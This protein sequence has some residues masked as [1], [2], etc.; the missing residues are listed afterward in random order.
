[1]VGQFIPSSGN[2]SFILSWGIRESREISLQKGYI[3][4]QK[5]ADHLHLSSQHIEAAQ[6]IYLM[7]LQRNFTMGRN[8]SYVA[9]SCLYTICR[10]EKSP[11]ML[12]DFSDILQTPVKPLGKTFLKLLR[13]LHINVPNIDPSLFL[14]RFAHKLNLK[15]D[16]Y[17]VTYTG[18]KLIQAMTRDWISTG[19]RP[20]G[21]CGAALLISTR[22]H[23]ISINSNTIAD[24]VRISNPTIIKRLSEFK[25]TNTAKIKASE[26]DKISI[27]DIPSNSIPPC[28]IYD[29]K[30]KLKH[31]FI[32]KNKTLS[33]CDS[34]E[35]DNRSRKS[36]SY[37][38]TFSDDIFS[39]KSNDENNLNMISNIND[40]N[41]S[42]DNNLSHID[43][44]SFNNNNNN[45]HSTNSITYDNK[46]KSSTESEKEKNINHSNNGINLEEI[47]NENP[48]G[49]DIDNLALKIINT[50]NIEN[51]PNI[52]KNVNNNFSINCDEKIDYTS[53]LEKC[54]FKKK[55]ELFMDN[56]SMKSTT[57]M[58]S[59]NKLSDME[60]YVS[61][62]NFSDNINELNKAKISDEKNSLINDEMK[63]GE[64]INTFINNDTNINDNISYGSND[65][66]SNSNMI[67]TMPNSS[68]SSNLSLSRNY[69][70]ET[71][72][73]E[74]NNIIESNN[75]TVSSNILEQNNLDKEKQ[76]IDSS[77][78]TTLKETVSCELNSILN[79][80]EDYN[81]LEC[82]I[83]NK[84]RNN[85]KNMNNVNILTDFNYFFEN[86]SN[87]VND[88][89][90]SFCGNSDTSI[91]QN[92]ETLSDIYDSEIE[93][94]ILTE[95]EKEVKMLIWDDM[96]KNYLPHICKQLKR[97]KKRSNEENNNEKKKIRNKKKKVEDYSETQSTGDSVLKAL[98]KSD[99]NLPNKINYDV[100]KSLFSS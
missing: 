98:E 17:K 93:S 30:K 47:C 19:R 20:T 29:N 42:N 78:C 1:M 63:N 46:E 44:P 54:E 65:D 11:I 23:G 50:I 49:N 97:Q 96:M 39:Q 5:I 32:E 10:R 74:T 94:M 35:Q 71:T 58:C 40:D 72:Y 51:N 59:I 99:K 31:N 7:A 86:N 52:L 92:D 36:I 18:I 75:N 16:I 67:K 43:G 21:L 2:K 34:E 89:N 83:Q 38:E 12:I 33:L 56:F 48:E 81:F 79:E 3:N 84:D 27:T 45:E 13:L 91:D 8:N 55:K 70:N 80:V 4:I 14:E 26:F 60:S 9:A 62:S 57:S 6:R 37:G 66:D 22:I 61:A 95:K 85:K 24:I 41:T 82:N 25:N 68:N 77:Y 69:Y 73:L 15:N 64:K 88:Q 76:K 28:V 100:L 87:S 90:T 53:N